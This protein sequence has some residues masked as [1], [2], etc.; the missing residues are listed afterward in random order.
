MIESLDET[1]ARLRRDGLS[2]YASTE[3]LGVINKAGLTNSEAKPW[4]L[5]RHSERQAAAD[6]DAIDGAEALRKA[7]THDR[8]VKLYP[9]VFDGGINI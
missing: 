5:R 8:F 1:D 9:K 4:L 7:K 3:D 2:K 6:R